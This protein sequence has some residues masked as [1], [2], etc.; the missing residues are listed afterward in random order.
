MR[1]HVL[2]DLHLE[3]GVFEPAVTDA[4]VIVLA[5]DIDVG[6]RGLEWAA[7]AFPGFAVVYVLGNHEYYGHS[8][9]KL[10]NAMRARAAELQLH[11]LEN[12]AVVLGG[13]RF[14]GMTL[15]TDFALT[16]HVAS[17]AEIA[18]AQMRDYRKIRIDPQY[19]KLQPYDTLGWHRGSRHWLETALAEPFDGATVVVSHHAPSPRSINPA[20]LKDEINAAYASDLEALIA[21]SP[22]NVWIH[23]HTHHNVDYWIGKTRVL[24]NQRGY[25]D[26]LS[27]GF[28]A[29][30][31]FEV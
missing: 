8:S 7:R 21:S 19:R 18:R 11:L 5:G 31:V 14:L 1:I 16:G 23:G 26:E 2:S 27:P 28:D 25:S 30:F 22:I 3:F 20:S 9:P 17:A 24:T 6:V 13:V 15:W 10:L 12:N 4:D 29:S